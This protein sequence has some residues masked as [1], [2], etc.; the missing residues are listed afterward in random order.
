MFTP[1]SI[2]LFAG[3]VEVRY[4]LPQYT[5]DSIKAL[6]IMPSTVLSALCALALVSDAFA[7]FMFEP[8]N[9]SNVQVRSMVHPWIRIQITSL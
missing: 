6:G 9:S 7:V 1:L 3:S 4:S 8:E 2:L 5:L